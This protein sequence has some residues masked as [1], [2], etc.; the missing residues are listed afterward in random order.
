VRAFLALVGEHEPGRPVFLFGHS[1]GALIVAEYVMR[2]PGGLAGAILSGLATEPAD[3]ANPVV[4]LLAP[5]LSR[6][7][8]TMVVTSDLDSAAL[9]RIP[10]VV[11]A[12]D[13][14]PLVHRQ[15][16]T[17]W[18]TESLRTVEWIK[19][20]GADIRLPI[21]LVHGEADPIALVKGSQA[22]F[23]QITFPDKTLR[24]YPGSYHEV[25]NDLDH[26]ELAADLVAWIEARLG[27]GGAA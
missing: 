20:H 26:A 21:L 11:Q 24:I 23:D 19:A 18:G 17:R 14:D 16:T 10:E 6:I 7:R 25:H 22:L 12:Y 8:P 9:S 2:D 5:V 3:L 4:V 13:Q 15:I 27:D 1:L